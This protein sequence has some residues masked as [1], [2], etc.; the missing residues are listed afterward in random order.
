M[1]ETYR[2]RMARQ[3]SS[4]RLANKYQS[5]AIMVHGF[6]N[7]Q[8]YRKVRIGGEEYDARILS[9][10]KTTVRGGNGNYVIQMKDDIPLKAGTYIEVPDAQGNYDYWLTLYMSLTLYYS[11]STLLKN[12]TI[13]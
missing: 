5:E 3:G 8:A 13:Y 6:E 7:S 9:D 2:K 10:S 11:Q 1:F 12:V 4:V